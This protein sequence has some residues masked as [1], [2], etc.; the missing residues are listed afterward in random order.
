MDRQIVYPGQIPLETDLLNSNRFAM[1]AIAKLA[2]AMLGTGTVA[3][4]LACAPTSPASPGPATPAP[5]A[6]GGSGPVWLIV[7]AVVVFGGGVG[8]GL[9]WYRRGRTR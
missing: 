9:W 8:L 2:A 7:A 3:N 1:I 6:S 5:S 4:G